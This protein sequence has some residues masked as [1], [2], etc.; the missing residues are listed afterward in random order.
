MKR[1]LIVRI[2]PEPSIKMGVE[3]MTVAVLELLKP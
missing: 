2:E 1:A 3:A